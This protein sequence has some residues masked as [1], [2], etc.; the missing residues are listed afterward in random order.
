LQQCLA[1]IKGAL[2]MQQASQATESICEGS[3]HGLRLHVGRR[4]GSGT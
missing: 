1:A 3:R 4:V 2:G